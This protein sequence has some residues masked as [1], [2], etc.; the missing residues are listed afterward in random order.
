MGIE[1]VMI[2]RRW[3]PKFW[4]FSHLECWRESQNCVPGVAAMQF[5]LNTSFSYHLAQFWSHFAIYFKAL[6]RVPSPPH[7]LAACDF[8][9]L[10][11]C[12]VH[13]NKCPFVHLQ[14]A[15]SYTTFYI[16]QDKSLTGNCLNCLHFSFLLLTSAA[17]IKGFISHTVKFI[18]RFKFLLSMSKDLKMPLCFYP[19]HLIITSY[20]PRLRPQNIFQIPI[21]FLYK[22]SGW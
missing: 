14:M 11:K 18:V 9:L 20:F 21:V 1:A 15:Q 16:K 8:K 13:N 2:V 7:S 4:S 6:S 19:Y 3:L 22:F 12:A 10:W 17:R 5:I